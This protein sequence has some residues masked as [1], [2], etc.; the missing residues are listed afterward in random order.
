MNFP[1]LQDVHIDFTYCGEK[2]FNSLPDD[3]LNLVCKKY[4]WPDEANTYV[5]TLSL[6]GCFLPMNQFKPD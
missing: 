6:S 3:I 2:L 1:F 4:Y 5:F